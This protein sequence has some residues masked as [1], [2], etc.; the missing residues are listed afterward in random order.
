MF[1]L[2]VCFILKPAGILDCKRLNVSG[3]GHLRVI[4]LGFHI[5]SVKQNFLN[6]NSNEHYN[7]CYQRAM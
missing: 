1:I 3:K 4:F 7:N 6:Q 5:K 2:P